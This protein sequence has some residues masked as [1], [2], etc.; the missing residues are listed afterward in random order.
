METPQ[1]PTDTEV[2]EF[3]GRL[4]TYRDTL[5]ESDQT[6]LDAMV[7]AAIGKKAGAEEEEEEV[8]SYWVAV[9]P[10]GPAGGVGY[11]YAAGGAYGAVGY[12]ATPW[13]AAYGA[14][15]W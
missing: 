1:M 9:N 12:T 14:R 11:G 2:K 13:G 7:A 3:L 10:V 4:K 15:V 5:P 8:Q 6:L